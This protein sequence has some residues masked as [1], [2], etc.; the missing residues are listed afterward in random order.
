MVN[1]PQPP[2]ILSRHAADLVIPQQPAL[3]KTY[4]CL[5]EWRL[6]HFHW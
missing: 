4:S 2:A 1:A 5:P 6:Q 3:A